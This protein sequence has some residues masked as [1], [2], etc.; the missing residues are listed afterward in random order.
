MCF[1]TII[2]PAFIGIIIRRPCGQIALPSNKK[3]QGKVK[4][5]L[6]IFQTLLDLK[7]GLIYQSLTLML[8]KSYI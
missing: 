2:N 6:F 8:G 5:G 7:G 4:G 3:C 1:I